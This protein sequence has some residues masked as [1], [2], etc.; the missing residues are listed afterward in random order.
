V[1]PV[2]FF[3]R[4]SVLV[5]AGK[6]GV[7][8][9]T[10]SA[11]IAVAAASCGLRV[12]AVELEGR[13]ELP[14]AL[15][16]DGTLTWDER[17]ALADA[18]GGAVAARRIRPDDA[19]VEWLQ[20]HAMGPVVRRL[21]TSGAL[22]VVAFAIPGIREVLV[23][24]KLKAIERTGDFDL[25]VV[26]A[27]ATGHAI[28][29]LTSPSGLATVARGGPVRRNTEEVTD[30][31]GDP[32]RCRVVLVTLPREL[33][34]DETI[35][36]A[37]EVEDRAGVKLSEV[38]VNQYVAPNAAL[39]EPLGASDAAL[40]APSIADAVEEARRF[41]SSRQHAA[42]AEVDRL[43]QALPLR[44]LTLPRLDADRIGPDETR[45]LANALLAEIVTVQ[46]TP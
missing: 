32:A 11:A 17:D 43:A 26:D 15:G 20:A 10:V 21:R 25:L 46:A 34:V 27:P 38:I 4:S 23:L 1:D 7:G 42:A 13:G 39:D 14:R 40:L 30:M 5:V 41:E 45:A 3:R 8:K 18:S 9:S 36:A 33:A 37:F 28:T 24:G 31:L 44:Q 2:A 19:L 12:L 29:L 22:E 16:L 35:E 6:G